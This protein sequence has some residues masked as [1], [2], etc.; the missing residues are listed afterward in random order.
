[1]SAWHLWIS[2]K[3]PWT[4]LPALFIRRN[5]A[6]HQAMQTMSGKTNS[7]RHSFIQ[8]TQTHPFHY[9]GIKFMS[10]MLLCNCNQ[11]IFINFQTFTKSCETIP[12]PYQTASTIATGTVEFRMC[13]LSFANSVHT[14]HSRNI[15][16]NFFETLSRA[17]Y[18][19]KTRTKRI[20]QTHL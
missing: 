10:T 14:D 9:I 11:T 17:L 15:W 19:D 4:F 5:H 20:C 8:C 7:F 12:F 2:R 13:G 3:V 16:A 18:V 6:F 1:M